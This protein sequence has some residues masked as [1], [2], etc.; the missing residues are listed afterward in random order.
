MEWETKCNVQVW[1]EPD[2]IKLIPF[3][4][5]CDSA[6]AAPP[7]CSFEAAWK[8]ASKLGAPSGNAVA[9]IMYSANIVTGK[10]EWYFDIGDWSESFP[11]GC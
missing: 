8:K 5:D 1:V 2:G 11:D 6:Y 9:S 3:E 4:W 7:K 10:V